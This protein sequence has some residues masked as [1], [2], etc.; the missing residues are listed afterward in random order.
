VGTSVEK[1]SIC[2]PPPEKWESVAP[3]GC[4]SRATKMRSNLDSSAGPTLR[5]SATAL[6][7]LYEKGRG[8]KHSLFLFF[9]FFSFCCFPLVTP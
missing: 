5:F 4:W 2:G 3:L 7:G 8:H 9:W 1:R 6:L